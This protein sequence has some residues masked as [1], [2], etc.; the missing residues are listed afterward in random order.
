[1]RIHGKICRMIQHWASLVGRFALLL[2][3]PYGISF[4]SSTS[5][6]TVNRAPERGFTADMTTKI[7]VA[8]ARSI[9]LRFDG[10]HF[11]TP[12]SKDRQVITSPEDRSLGRLTAGGAPPPATLALAA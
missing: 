7:H 5:L 12:G 4:M 3:W 1:M 11:A 9:W 6:L 8:C 10:G 2:E